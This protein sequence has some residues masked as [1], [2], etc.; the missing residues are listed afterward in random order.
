MKK[1]IIAIVLVVAAAL[2]GGLIWYTQRPARVAE[3]AVEQLAATD[4]ANYRLQLQL[5]NVAASQQ[6]LGEQGSIE[7][8]AVGAF[9]REGEDTAER[10]ALQADIVLLTKTE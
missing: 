10:S 8:T 4:T 2:A 9:A 7:F 5:E 6:V 3:A 1:G